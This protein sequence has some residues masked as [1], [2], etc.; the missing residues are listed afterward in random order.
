V[1]RRL[2]RYRSLRKSPPADATIV[3]M[4]MMAERT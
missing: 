1:T 3:K 2:S 4:A